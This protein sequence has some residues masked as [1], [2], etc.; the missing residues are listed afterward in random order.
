MTA[1]RVW[2][3]AEA[4]EIPVSYFYEGLSQKNETPEGTQASMAREGEL[5]VAA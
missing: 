3:L 2:H 5:Q 4:L 1:S